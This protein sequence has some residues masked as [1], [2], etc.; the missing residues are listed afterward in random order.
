MVYSIRVHLREGKGEC[1]VRGDKRS[2]I[3]F[4]VGDLQLVVGD[5][6]LVFGGHPGIGYRRGSPGSAP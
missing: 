3:A 4:R 1:R 2:A 5:A 6:R